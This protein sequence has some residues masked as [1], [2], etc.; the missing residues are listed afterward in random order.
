M[1]TSETFIPVIFAIMAFMVISITAFLAAKIARIPFP[2]MLVFSGVILSQTPIP[3]GINLFLSAE[4]AQQTIIFVLLPILIFDAA[5]RFDVSKFAA[6]WVPIVLM[7]FPGVLFSMLVITCSLIFLAGLTPEVA[8]LLGIILSATD[9]SATIAIFKELGAPKDLVTIVEGESLLNDATVIA[10]YKV[11]AVVLAVNLTPYEMALTSSW[12]ILWLFGAGAIS[13]WIAGNLLIWLMRTLPDE[14]YIEISISLIIA[15]GCFVAIEEYMGAS[16]IV[17]LTV[18]G[19]VL[20]QNTPLPI[21]NNSSHY[22]ENFWTYLSDVS[23]A[24]VFILVG[25]WLDISLIASHWLSSLLA[26]I[27]MLLARSILVYG[28]LPFFG[29][30]RQHSYLLP[31]AY[32]HICLWGGLR[33]AVTLALAM[34]AITHTAVLNLEQKETLLAI[35]MGAVA[36]II[37]IQGLTL[38]PLARYLTLDDISLDNQITKKELLLSAMSASKHALSQFIQTPLSSSGAPQELML[39]LKSCLSEE[40]KQLEHLYSEQVGTEGL[41][42]RLIMR[43]LSIE[44]GYLYILYEQGIIS[45]EIYQFQRESF[46]RQMDA[47]RHKYRQPKS[48]LIAGYWKSKL[49]GHPGSRK[50]GIVFQYEVSWARLLTSEFALTEL[51]SLLAEQPV[52]KLFTDQVFSIWRS[53]HQQSEAMIRRL[54]KEHP[55]LTA[56]AQRRWLHQMLNTIHSSHLNKFVRQRLINASERDVIREELMKMMSNKIQKDSGR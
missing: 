20:S 35:A 55:V 34:L 21:S 17:A 47:A 37:I 42:R 18:C 29:Q 46:D 4:V 24:F 49:F 1:D 32:Q 44:A 39:S 6:N 28:V 16:G 41:Y 51:E 53:W 5:Y 3:S 19:L 40:Q 26:V 50:Q 31:K 36:F 12:K 2:I 45:S 10:L 22:L 43:G 14:P 15:V 25:M 52:N 48:L 54:E 27:C 13:G 33:G 9:P 8:L 30:L 11:A 38:S 23:K 7:A 56:Q